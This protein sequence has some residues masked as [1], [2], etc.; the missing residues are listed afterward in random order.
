MGQ[1]RAIDIVGL[2]TSVSKVD[3]LFECVTISSIKVLRCVIVSQ[4]LYNRCD[5]QNLDLKQ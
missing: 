1:V 5:R 3:L 2:N 4:K